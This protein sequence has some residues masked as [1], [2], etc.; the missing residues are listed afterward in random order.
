L[1]LG[2]FGKVYEARTIE[3]LNSIVNRENHIDAFFVASELG[4]GIVRSLKQQYPA[5]VYVIGNCRFPRWAKLT[6]Q[7]WKTCSRFPWMSGGSKI[8]LT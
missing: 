3:E 5:P 4:P 1:T 2:A 6:Q 8:V 7:A